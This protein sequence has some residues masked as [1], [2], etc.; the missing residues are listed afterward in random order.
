MIK[1]SKDNV[2]NTGL[3]A[4]VAG[5]VPMWISPNMLTCLRLV[6]SLCIVFVDVFQASLWWV[7]GL[8][9]CAGMTD[10]LDGAVA[11]HRGQITTLGAYLDPLGDKVLGA[12][13]G[14]VLW[15]RGVLPGLP[16]ALVLLA[17][18]HA[19]LLPLMHFVRRRMRGLSAFPLPK[20]QANVFGKWKFGALAWGMAFLMLG[21]LLDWSF[22]RGLGSFGVWLAVVLGWIAFVRYI[23]DWAKGQWN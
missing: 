18:S 14:Y 19:L 10:F 2:G 11:R 1:R 7:L 22:G 21:D 9:F 23:Y 8:G 13:V 15:R 6:M 3:Q 20:A 12:V 4:R 17:E 5:L 16:L